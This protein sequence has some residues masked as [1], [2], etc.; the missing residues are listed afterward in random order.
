MSSCDAP[1]RTR[2]LFFIIVNIIAISREIE[3]PTQLL[4]RSGSTHC[5]VNIMSADV[6]LQQPLLDSRDDQP[7][8]DCE[9]GV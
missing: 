3:K 5:V 1:G 4:T 8:E 7:V 6:G 9:G 2:Q